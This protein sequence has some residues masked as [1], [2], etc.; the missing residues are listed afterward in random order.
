MDILETCTLIRPKNE[1][2]CQ[3]SLLGASE[4]R[5]SRETQPR[6]RE[7]TVLRTMPGSDEMAHG[8]ES[9]SAMGSVCPGLYHS[10]GNATEESGGSVVLVKMLLL[11]NT[12]FFLPNM[13]FFPYPC[14]NKGHT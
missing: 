8:L 12:P 14:F 6:Q 13:L 3:I 1:V 9:L 10:L 11:Q 5:A 4:G 2:S 7:Q